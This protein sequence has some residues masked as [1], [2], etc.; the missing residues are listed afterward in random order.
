[1][2]KLRSLFFIAIT[3]IMIIGMCGCINS[4]KHTK[5]ILS[6]L[7][8]KHNREFEITALRYEVDGSGEG[9]RFRATCRAVGEKDTFS[10]TYFPK[11]N[12]T[13]KPE[14]RDG[15]TDML[16]NKMYVEYIEEQY[17]EVLFSLSD[18]AVRGYEFTIEDIKKGIEHCW[19]CADYDES[20]DE[21]VLLFVFANEDIDRDAFEEKFISERL[22]KNFY[23]QLIG[24]AY[25]DENAVDEIK[26]KYYADFD[27]LYNDVPDDELVSSCNYYYLKEDIGIEEFENRK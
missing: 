26:A 14:F 21:V 7:S 15:Y 9:P 16:F 23:K 3:L 18:S 5:E 17:P 24:V 2:K 20:Y 4:K 27:M 19:S 8:E 13:G 12:F 6:R 25:V 10:V 1:M 22:E 11:N